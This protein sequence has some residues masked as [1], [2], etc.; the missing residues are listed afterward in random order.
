MRQGFISSEDLVSR[1]K[2][3]A[4]VEHIGTGVFKAFAFA[5]PKDIDRLGT[6]SEMVEAIA[7]S[8]EEATRH[9]VTLA[10]ALRSSILLRGD[11]VEGL[12]IN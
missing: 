12:E 9:L 4:R 5:I 1:F 2:I 10:L 7:A 8:G 3:H 11:S 6:K